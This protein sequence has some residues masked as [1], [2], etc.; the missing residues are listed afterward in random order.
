MS[1]II[2]LLTLTEGRSMILFT[3]KSDMQFVYTQL[4]EKNLSWSLFVQQ[5][6]SS[7]EAVKKK[8][9]EDEHSILLST[10][11]FWEGIDIP[12]SSLSNLI[13]FKLPFPVPDPILEYKASRSLNG[14][15]EV[16]LPEMLIKLRQ[17][18]GRLIRKE[19]DRGIATILDS[20]ISSV[21]NKNYRDNVIDSLPFR[22]IT[23][24][25][26]VVKEFVRDVL[27]FK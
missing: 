4:K 2:K 24:D 25:F 20:R 26:E 16:Y 22:N 8:F 17:G 12:G 10:G 14:F 13:I 18:L 15:S 1:E 23:E 5:E 11:I 7:Q 6:G 21:Q 19:N 3:S 27:K 9:L